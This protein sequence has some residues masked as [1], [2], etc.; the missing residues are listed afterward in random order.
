LIVVRPAA[1]APDVVARETDV[2]PAE[3]RDM[4]RDFLV[5]RLPL[6]AE[7]VECGGEVPRVPKNDGGDQ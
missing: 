1:F 7:A 6:V 2:F 3:R 4:L 5:Q